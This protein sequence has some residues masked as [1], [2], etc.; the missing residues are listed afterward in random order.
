MVIC[1]SY[2]EK[3]EWH[4]IL[5]G[6]GALYYSFFVLLIRHWV[7]QFAAAEVEPLMHIDLSIT[8]HVPLSQR[9]L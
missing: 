5:F 6:D 9:E 3:N 8:C 1:K 2:C 7:L 4:I